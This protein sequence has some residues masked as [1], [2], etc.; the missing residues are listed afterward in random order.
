MWPSVDQSAFSSIKWGCQY[1]LP[2]KYTKHLKLYLIVETVD[3][4]TDI[5]GTHANDFI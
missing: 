3:S 5:K 1:Y 2:Y 4:Q